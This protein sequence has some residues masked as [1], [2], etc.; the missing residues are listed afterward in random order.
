MPPRTPDS[1][2]W[3]KYLKRKLTKKEKEL[4]DNT[5]EEYLINRNMKFMF[6]NYQSQMVIVYLI[7]FVII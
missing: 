3:A 5:E 7:L 6:Q 1:K 4:I 2:K